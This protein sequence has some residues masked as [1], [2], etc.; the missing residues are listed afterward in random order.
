MSSVFVDMTV[1]AARCIPRLHPR[2]GSDPQPGRVC[3][4]I[5]LCSS[6]DHTI[7]SC[8][9]DVVPL[10]PLVRGHRRTSLAN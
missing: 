4:P 7:L 1:L 5:S 10:T 9:S 2:Q 3:R 8:V 6:T